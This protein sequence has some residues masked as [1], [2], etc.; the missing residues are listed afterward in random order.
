MPGRPWLS[1]E[2]ASVRGRPA[3]GWRLAAPPTGTPRRPRAEYVVVDEL[4]EGV[5]AVVCEPWPE[6][7]RRGRLCFPRPD[8]RL[9]AEVDPAALQ[10]LLASRTPLASLAP[11]QRPAFA[12]R[13][14]RAGDVFCAVVDRKALAADP[15]AVT[16]WL[17]V[18]VIDVS[19][20][21][22]EAAK[23]QYYAAVG[24]VLTGDELDGLAADFFDEHGGQAQG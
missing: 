9:G 5:A 13:P 3:R 6:L 20:Q 1:E 19:A 22:R 17:G 2:I 8:L 10:L 18:P 24:P 14:L 21:A 7:D 4:E 16:E 11:G 15:G 23:A 12:A